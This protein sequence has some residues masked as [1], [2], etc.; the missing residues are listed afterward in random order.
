MAKQIENKYLK[1]KEK[2]KKIL[3]KIIRMF[4]VWL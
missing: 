3:H 2:K 1:K 4:I